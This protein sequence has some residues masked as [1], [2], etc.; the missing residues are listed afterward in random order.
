MNEYK[1]NNNRRGKVIDII[2]QGISVLSIVLA[3]LIA[4]AVFDIVVLGKPIG[5]EITGVDSTYLNLINKNGVT[6]QNIPFKQGVKYADIGSIG[7]KKYVIVITKEEESDILVLI[8]FGHYKE[9]EWDTLRL[10]PDSLNDL[11]PEGGF[12]PHCNIIA[13]KDIKVGDFLPDTIYPGNEICILAGDPHWSSNFVAVYDDTLNE[14]YFKYFTFGATGPIWV[15]DFDRDNYAEILVAGVNN[16]ISYRE[17][18]LRS[19]WPRGSQYLYCIFYVDPLT[20]SFEQ[21]KGRNEY[22]AP[23]SIYRGIPVFPNGWYYLWASGK[24]T[25][26]WWQVTEIADVDKDSIDELQL[27][28]RG[29]LYINIQIDSGNVESVTLTDA[30]FDT[31]VEVGKA[32]LYSVRR[33]AG[34]LNFDSLG[35]PGL[36]KEALKRE[37]DWEEIPY[38]KR[39]I[40]GTNIFQE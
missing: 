25:N 8:E 39:G 26:P 32:D 36:I 24:G 3:C 16:T 17:K 27:G 4:L 19:P 38:P 2:F 9:N 10:H 29:G 6:I 18:Y 35:V 15:G 31:T 34:E 12:V 7:G 11:L 1:P 30:F 23:D 40:T 13:I 22:Q 37:D 28:T 33:V 20:M 21:G 14:A 5:L